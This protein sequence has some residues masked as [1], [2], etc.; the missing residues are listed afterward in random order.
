MFHVLIVNF[1]RFLAQFEKE[2]YDVKSPIWDVDFTHNISKLPASGIGKNHLGFIIYETTCCD[3]F[4]AYHVVHYA[5]FMVYH[6]KN[7]FGVII[8]MFEKGCM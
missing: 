1:F 7:G 8:Y 4:M 3:I 2:V 5:F 6:G